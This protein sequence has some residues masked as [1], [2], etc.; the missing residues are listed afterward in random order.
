MKHFARVEAVVPINPFTIRIKNDDHTPLR[1]VLFDPLFKKDKIRLDSP[2]WEEIELGKPF[3]YR[4]YLDKYFAL[5]ETST[6][7]ELYVW[8]PVLSQYLDL[9]TLHAYHATPKEDEFEHL[10][11]FPTRLNPQQNRSDVAFVQCDFKLDKTTRFGFYMPP[12]STVLFDFYPKTTEMQ[13]V[14]VSHQLQAEVGKLSNYYYT[15]KDPYQV[16]AM[17]EKIWVPNKLVYMKDDISD[18]LDSVSEKI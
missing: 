12:N 18:H 14:E 8:S 10:K 2:E 16:G 4:R 9:F 7:T 6:I 3:N 1:T 13:E 11:I 15:K 5:W 17:S